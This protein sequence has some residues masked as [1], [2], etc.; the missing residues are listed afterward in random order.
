MTETT[1]QYHHLLCAISGAS[2]VISELPYH[3]IPNEK[4]D[5]LLRSHSFLCHAAIEEYLE[6]VSLFVLTTSY[7]EYLADGKMR[8]PLAAVS[9]HYKIPLEKFYSK[10]LEDK[11]LVDFHRLSLPFALD[12]HRAIVRGNNG[13]RTNNQD[14][15]LVPLGIRMFEYDKILSYD[16]ESFGV[17]RGELAH[18]FRI[19]S[20]LPRAALEKT[21]TQLVDLL[22]DLDV[23]LNGRVKRTCR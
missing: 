21:I 6:N 15:L 9:L 3:S 14:A 11:E 4:T 16:L 20:K 13:I 1:P 12:Q 10:M 8:E 2:K 7:N 5:L 23:E 22:Y 17:R 18:K 19:T